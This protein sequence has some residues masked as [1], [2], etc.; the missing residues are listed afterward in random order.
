MIANG[1]TVMIGGFMGVGTPTRLI[2]ALVERQVRDLTIIANDSGLPGVGIGKLV[3]AGA[4]RALITSHIGLN[5]ETQKEMNAN[6][7]SVQLVPQGTLVER[8][9]AAGVGLGGVMTSTGIGTEVEIGKDVIEIDGN[10]YLLETPLR[11]DVALIAARRADHVGNLE[12]SLTAQNF[13]PIMALAADVVI[14]ETESIVP[15]GVIPPD[16]VRTPGVLV[17]HLIKRP[18]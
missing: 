14:A 4:V 18:I 10:Q 6:R 12:Y 5:P 17:D 3:T 1:S 8:I 7:I 9:R 2:D 11:A 15:I 16:A 13:N